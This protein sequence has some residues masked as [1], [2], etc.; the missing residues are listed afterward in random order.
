M[1]LNIFQFHRILYRA[2][3]CTTMHFSTSCLSKA[4]L[5]CL[6]DILVQ[7]HDLIWNIFKYVSYRN[8]NVKIKTLD[9]DAVLLSQSSYY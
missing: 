3:N 6:V 5:S 7:F 9:K 4:D 1:K 2:Y 8:T